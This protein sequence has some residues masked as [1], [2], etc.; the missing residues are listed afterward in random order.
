[1]P[2]TDN[3]AA[4]EQVRRALRREPRIAFDRQQIGLNF[5][6]GELLLSGEVGDIAAKRLAVARAVA[7]PEV[8]TVFDELR[9]RPAEILPDAEIGD[10]VR[11]V[12][13][14]EPALTGCALRQRIGIRFQSVHSPPT[15]VGRIDFA[16]ARGVVSLSG[17]APSLA[18][19]RLA[20]ALAWRVAGTRDVVNSLDVRPPEEDSDDAL[21]D[22]VRLVLDRDLT[23]HAVQIRVA[24]R[25]GQVGLD[26]TVGAAAEVAA[27]EHDA[28]FV[29]GVRDVVNR[30][31]VSS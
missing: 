30:L 4:I 29:F 31:V 17:E 18:Q 6:N 1:M 13:V 8:T 20:G 15:A 24:A 19:K 23:V 14:E 10:L 26:G 2:M 16:V 27:A 22:A 5:A 9:I 3:E 25:D 21:C 28:W 12:L 7:V 11:R